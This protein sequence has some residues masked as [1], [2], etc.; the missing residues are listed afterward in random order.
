MIEQV[1]MLYSTVS[2]RAL[3]SNAKEGRSVSYICDYFY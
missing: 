3:R 1:L 2:L